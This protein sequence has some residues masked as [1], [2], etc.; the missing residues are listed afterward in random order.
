[1]DDGLLK[2][3][4][5]AVA[6]IIFFVFLGTIGPKPTIMVMD[7]SAELAQ[8]EAQRN[9]VAQAMMEPNPLRKTQIL[10]RISKFKQENDRTVNPTRNRD[11]SPG[12]RFLRANGV[13][14]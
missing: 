1:V 7:T 13:V 11:S 6:A 14:R 12:M 2:V 4:V 3:A 10:K 9:V 8:V 5:A